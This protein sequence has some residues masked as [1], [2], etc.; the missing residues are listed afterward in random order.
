FSILRAFPTHGKLILVGDVDQL[1]SVGPGLVLK[2]LISSKILPVVR[3]DTI[4]RQAQESLIITNA[5]RVN[6][7]IMPVLVKPDGQTVTD[8]YFLEAPEPA[9]SL[10]LMKNVVSSSLPKRF[11]Y[12]PIEDIQVLTPMRRASLGAQNLNQ[13]LQE[14]LNPPNPMKSELK[15]MH[16]VFRVGDKV[17]QQRNNYDLE[18]FNGDIGIIRTINSEDQEIVIEFG[19][20]ERVYQLADLLDL[21]HA[22][23]ITVH[24]SQGSEYKAVVIVLMTQHYMMLQRN[25]FYTALTRAKKTAVIIGTRKALW[26]AIKNDKVKNRNTIFGELLLEKYPQSQN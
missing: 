26:I 13:L 24:K 14:A 10:D 2:H 7:G 4:F 11:G 12:H 20:G 16:R 15:H 5:H 3:L 8:C 17:I 23:A 1:P 25:L 18:V 19:Q 22:Y 21:D 9:N 6:K